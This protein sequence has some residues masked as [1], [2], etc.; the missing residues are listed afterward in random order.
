MFKADYY[1]MTGRN[2]DGFIKRIFTIITHHNLKYMFYFRKYQSNRNNKFAQY[3]LLK[4]SRKYGLEISSNA[5]IGKGVYLGH[6][7]CITVNGEAEIG[8]YV[9]LHKGCTIGRENRGSRE[10]APKIGNKVYVGINSTI[11][12]NITIGDD[13]MIAPNT[14][15]N[16]DVPSHSIVI[17]DKASIHSKEDATNGYINFCS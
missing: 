11:V 4:M 6:P 16:F 17:G 8:N 1:R 15:V 14:Y 3:K 10:G 12:G 7:Y 2:N 13:V 5:K 9:S